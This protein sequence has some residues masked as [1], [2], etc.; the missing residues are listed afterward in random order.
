MDIP[1]AEIAAFAR[2]LMNDLHHSY[3]LL[4]EREIIV[5]AASGVGVDT[6]GPLADLQLARI[7]VVEEIETALRLWLTAHNV[8]VAEA[9]DLTEPESGA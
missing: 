3:P 4:L 7:R 8:P 9:G 1:D 6:Q 5:E 2:Q